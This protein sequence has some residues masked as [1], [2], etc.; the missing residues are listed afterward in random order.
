M[1]GFT[2]FSNIRAISIIVSHDFTCRVLV[3]LALDVAQN[4][5]FIMIT[6]KTSVHYIQIQSKL[7]LFRPIRLINCSTKAVKTVVT[8]WQPNGNKS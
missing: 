4:Y 3:S 2:Y 8:N 7:S 1:T 5:L 6:F